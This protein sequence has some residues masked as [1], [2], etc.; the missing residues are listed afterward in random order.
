MVTRN[1]CSCVHS[2][3][4]SLILCNLHTHKKPNT[5][6]ILKSRLEQC[7]FGFNYWIQHF[8]KRQSLH[9]IKTQLLPASLL[10]LNQMTQE[11]LLRAPNLLCPY[12]PT[13]RPETRLPAA[14]CPSMSAASGLRWLSTAL[15]KGLGLRCEPSES[16]WETVTSTPF[17][18]WSGYVI[19]S[20]T[21]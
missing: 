9:L 20:G 19:L 3:L 7:L 16:T 1:E 18:T 15:G 17:I 8:K 6:F 5:L 13:P 21:D 11:V 14:I 12:H 4:Y 2:A 10:L